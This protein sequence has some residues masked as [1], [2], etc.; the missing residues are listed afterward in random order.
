[1]K[2]RQRVKLFIILGVEFIAIAIMLLL[3]FFAGKQ[4][5]T[6]TFDLNGGILLGGDPIQRVTQGHSATPP[7]TAKD[8]HYFL[9]WSGSYSRVTHDVTVYAIWEYE[10]SPGIEYNVKEDSN[11]CTIAGGFKGLQGEIYV[12]AYHNGLKALGIEDNA[13]E[14]CEGVTA[15]HFLDGALTIGN[16]AFAGCVSLESI[17]LPNTVFSMGNGV[18]KGCESLTSVTLPRDLRT[19]G[20]DSFRNCT[21]LE[22]V[23][24]P[25]GLTRIGAYAFAGCENLK[26]IVLPSTLQSIDDS[27]F[28]GCT[29]LEE[30]VFGEVEYI[31]NSAFAGCENLTE[32][33]LPDGVLHIGDNAFAG[34]TALE[35]VSFFA[36]VEEMGRGVFDGKLTITLC[37]YDET[38]ETV[39]ETWVSDWK[40][41]GVTVEWKYF[42]KPAEEET[43]DVIVDEDETSTKSSKKR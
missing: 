34:C 13:F 20:D 11:Y 31:G 35:N 30:V 43:S 28:F 32:I 23:V 26:S 42:E 5:Y 3:I 10:T 22:T 7:S 12:G 33:A 29:A 14:N 16:G 40:T 21:A 18:F 37:S 24:L 9:R 19:L 41:D 36:T 25:E 27:A 2:T 6:V 17:D 39:P 4:S 38:Q 8:G 1:M 15:F